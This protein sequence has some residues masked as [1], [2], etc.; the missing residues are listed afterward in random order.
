MNHTLK[1]WAHQ[2]N[3]YVAHSDRL[4]Q[5]N[6]VFSAGFFQHYQRDDV[7]RTHLF[8]SRYENTYLTEQHITELSQLRQE[9]CQLA[10][11]ILGLENIEMGF[12]FNHMPPGAV[13]TAHRHDDDDEL[14]SAAYYI[15]VPENSGDFIIHTSN[16]PAE[17]ETITIT[18]VE[19]SFLFFKPSMV[20][21]VTENLSHQHRLSIG[22][23]F[24][25]RNRDD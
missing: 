8:N 4:K 21:A 12:W 14:L 17:S 24:G 1:K 6:P 3:I 15:S 2:D 11:L 23:N 10:S 25:Q 20:H 19:G 9:A 22:I 16:L 13:T 7:K 5:L 18:P